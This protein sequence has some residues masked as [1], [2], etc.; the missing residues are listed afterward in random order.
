MKAP[1]VAPIILTLKRYENL[2]K[3]RQNTWYDNIYFLA[4][5]IVK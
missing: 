4:K 2:N 1:I 3:F 5:P